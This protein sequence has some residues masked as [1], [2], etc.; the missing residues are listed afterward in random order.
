MPTPEKYSVRYLPHGEVTVYAEREGE[1]FHCGLGPVAESKLLYV[2]QL[3]LD[4]RW[5]SSTKSTPLV[6]WDV[7]LGAAANAMAV[8]SSWKASKSGHLHLVSFDQTLGPLKCALDAHQKDASHF[9][10]LNG[11]DWDELIAKKSIVIEGTEKSLIWEWKFGDFVEELKQA[12]E[13]NRAWP[14]PH[15][16]LYDCY[17]PARNWEMWKLE[18]W[19]NL[20]K[21]CGGENT[22]IVSYSRATGMRVTLLLA[23]FYVGRGCATGIKPE[24]TL[25][26]TRP[27]NLRDL[28]DLRW[29]E[30]V[31]R[32]HTSHPFTTEHFE[33]NPIDERWLTELRRHPQFAGLIGHPI[34]S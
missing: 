21:F 14:V 32:S 12:A 26:S 31:Q 20:R 6:I 5:S 13:G 3:E 29:F 28:L 15:A 7:G 23:G 4:T 17:S 9:G 1:T 2:D 30:R 10:Y 25:A 27:E 33:G 18:H 8:L 34:I 16:V 22:T 19:E 24:T 11:W